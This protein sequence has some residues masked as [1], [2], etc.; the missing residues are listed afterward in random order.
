MKRGP[1]VRE[2]KILSVTGLLDIVRAAFK[3]ITAPINGRKLS[4]ADCLMSALAMFSLKSPSLLAFDQGRAEPIVQE[5]LRMLFKIEKV[6]CD[7]HMREVLDEVDPKELRECYLTVF[8]DAQ[9]GKLLE[10]YKF[11]GGYLCLVDGTD[12]G[13]FASKYCGP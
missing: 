13:E 3:K 6:P 9:R 7:T 8:H 5:N 2:K 1:Q 11:L 12:K 10:R 4:L